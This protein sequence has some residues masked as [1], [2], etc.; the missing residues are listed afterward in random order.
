[1]SANFH[2]INKLTYAKL[3]HDISNLS[4]GAVTIFRP[5]IEKWLN[6]YEGLK[7]EI[8]SDN[9]KMQKLH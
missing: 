5:Y 1:M 8:K 6:K 3:S 9:T 7:A 2:N 4:C